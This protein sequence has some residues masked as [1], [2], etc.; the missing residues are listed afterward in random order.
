MSEKF[1]SVYN[2]WARLYL[3]AALALA[4]FALDAAAQPSINE[5]PITSENTGVEWKFITAGPRAIGDQ[6]NYIDI[7]SIQRGTLTY[8]THRIV[9]N[10]GGE[11]INKWVA[12]C[13]AGQLQFLG[14]IRYDDHGTEQSRIKG[15]STPFKAGIEL[16]KQ[17]LKVVCT[18]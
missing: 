2:G 7:A 11:Q 14:G 16:H 5:T 15:T 8:F 9:I 17:M 4:C 13:G 1:F 3:A 18:R 12:S 6:M 10:E